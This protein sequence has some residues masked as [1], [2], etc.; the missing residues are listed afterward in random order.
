LEIER[1]G[2]TDSSIT[3]RIRQ[4]ERR[5]PGVENTLEDI[6]I[7]GKENTKAKSS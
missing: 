7:T 5:I 2:V 3:N 4:T 6:D 1:S